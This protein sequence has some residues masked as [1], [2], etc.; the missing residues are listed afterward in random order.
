MLKP[1]SRAPE[2]PKSADPL[3]KVF[4]L[5]HV[6][7][8]ISDLRANYPS[9]KDN[10]ELNFLYDAIYALYSEHATGEIDLRDI[11]RFYN[12][13]MSHLKAIAQSRAGTIDMGDGKRFTIPS[14]LPLD[15]AGFIVRME[16]RFDAE[17][18]IDAKEAAAGMI[19]LGELTDINRIIAS[20]RET[21][22]D[23]IIDLIVDSYHVDITDKG[24]EEVPSIEEKT[25]GD[26]LPLLALDDEALK[27][28]SIHPELIETILLIRGEIREGRESA[29]EDPQVRREFAERILSRPKPT[30]TLFDGGA[31]VDRPGK[32]K[33]SPK[34]HGTPSGNSGGDAAE[35]KVQDVA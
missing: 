27:V 5:G 6:A 35:T 12:E 25:L 21:V 31:D 10:R 22:E 8:Q 24:D 20:M 4:T 9:L 7:A 19:V 32:A 34:D 13:L 1:V 17:Y 18:F 28:A 29:P 14:T 2:S 16:D 3:F 15:F 23:C 30:L 33:G 11:E 26:L